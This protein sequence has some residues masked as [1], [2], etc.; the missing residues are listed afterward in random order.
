MFSAFATSVILF[1]VNFPKYDNSM[2]RKGILVH[3][4]YKGKLYIQEWMYL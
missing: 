1:L 3:G 2:R 4:K